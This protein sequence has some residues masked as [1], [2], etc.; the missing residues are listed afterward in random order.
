[1]QILD[2]LKAEGIKATFGMT[3]VWAEDNPDLIKRMVAEGHQ[4][5]NHTYDHQSFTGNSTGAAPLTTAQRL[6]EIRHTE[7]VVSSIAGYDLRPYFRPPYGDYDQSVLR[8]I[9]EAGYTVNVMWTVD[10]LGWNGLS[11]AQII[12]RCVHAAK[13]G[14]VLLMHVGSQSQEASALPELIH[15]LRAQGY[16]FVTVREMVGR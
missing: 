16:R 2:T 6:D 14:A 11:A 5:M 12:E 13:P 15:Q 8:D 7:Q 10:C 4:L 3:G 9:A 1:G